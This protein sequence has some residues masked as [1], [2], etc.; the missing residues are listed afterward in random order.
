MRSEEHT[1]E[2]QSHRDLHSFPTR[3]S[4][5]L[6]TEW[7]KRGSCLL[8]AAVKT[9]HSISWNLFKMLRITDY[10]LAAL[11]KVG[12]KQFRLALCVFFLFRTLLLNWQRQLYPE[13]P[14]TIV[15][16]FLVGRRPGKTAQQRK[17]QPQESCH[18]CEM[19]VCERKDMRASCSAKLYCEF[20]NFPA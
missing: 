4:S 9:S 14:F 13:M 18:V 1:S 17:W 10:V 7:S 19:H 2:L 8:I 11:T 3:R 15:F 12:Q 20:V 5:D 16:H 6:L